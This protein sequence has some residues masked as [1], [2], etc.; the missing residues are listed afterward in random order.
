MMAGPVLRSCLR[1]ACGF[2]SVVLTGATTE[3]RIVRIE[4]SSTESPALEGRRFGAVGQFEKLR[5]KAYGEVDPADPRNRVI[6]DLHL[7]PKNANGKVEYSTDIFILKP[8]DMSRG[9]RRLFVDINNRGS[10]RWITLNG[11][12]NADNPTAAADAGSGFLMDLGYTIVGNGW[13]AGAAPGSDRLMISVP[14][15]KNGDGSPVIGPSYEYISFTDGRQLRYG[16]T[17]PSASLDTAKAKLT[18]R[19]RLDDPPVAVAAGGWEYIDERSIRLLPAGTPFTQ[20]HIYE[21]TYSATHPVVA[22]LGLAAT[23]DLISFL[24]YEARDRQGTPNPLAGA[25]RHTLSFAIS[26]SAR[27]IN[28]FQTLG[29]NE[30]ERGRQVLDGVLNWIGGPNGANINYRFAQ[31]NRTERNRQHHLYPEGLF[32]F[33]YPVLT[34]HVTGRT[35][36]RSRRCAVSSTCPKAFEVNS[37]NEYWVKAASLLHTDTKGR[38]LPDPPQV[39]FYLLS[40]LQHG[41]G[42]FTRRGICQQLTNGTSGD[43]VLRALLVALDDWV[44]KG[45][46]PPPSAVPRQADQTAV[47]AT[48]RPG[49]Q[50][51]VVPANA[52]GWPTIPGVIY[53][54]LITTRYFLDFG[55]RFQKAGIISHAPPSLE[56]RP[57]YTHFVSRVDED[58]NEV[59]GVRLPEVAAPTGTTTGWALRRAEFGEND[60]CEAVG[61]YIPFKTTRADRLSAGDPRPSLEERHQTHAGYVRAVTTAARD[62]EKRRLLL[63]EDVERYIDAAGSGPVLRAQSSR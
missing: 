3:A 16:L 60:G 6:T 59:A 32:P 22:G 58:G 23:R 27:Y 40:G 55:P 18:V 14:I 49:Y 9:N 53:T 48:P 30:D 20:G 12:R 50:T 28:D 31:T 51:G 61:Q 34:D 7:A 17:Y 21:F 62:L 45:I 26:Q 13:D 52:L 54:G 63:A 47:V 33:A 5:G 36:G 38:D 29:F 15:V 41:T 8:I 57:A 11:G 2:M 44:T 35:D 1:V 39:R 19:A 10:M 56:G 24:R 37:A 43:P 46:E 42:D 25:V 4:I